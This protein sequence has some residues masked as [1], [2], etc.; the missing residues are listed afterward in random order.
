MK[1]TFTQSM[2]ISETMCFDDVYERSLQMDV[3]EKTDLLA[4][5]S[6]AVWMLVDGV[7]AGECY[8]AP[9]AK[10][11][12]DI[13]DVTDYGPHSLYCYSTTILPRFQGLGLSKILVAY[14]NGLASGHGFRNVC[15]HATSPAMVAVRA[16]FGA[17]FGAVHEHWYE[18]N[19][20]AHFY[21]QAL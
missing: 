11:D 17:R 4:R 7:L 12:E 6:V 18:T 20:T 1:V 9:T 14:W 5:S 10:F 2:P 15:G 19:R 21:E 8:G 3:A 16:F 13:E